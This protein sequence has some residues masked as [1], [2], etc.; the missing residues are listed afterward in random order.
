MSETYVYIDGFN[1]YYGCIKGTA[2]KWLDLDAFCQRL[3]PKDDIQQIRYFTAKVAARPHD[4]QAP[5]RQETYLRALATIPKLSIHFGHFL[6]NI[7]TLPLARP[8]RIGSRKAQVVKT[9]EKGSDVN[10]AAHA[11]L[12]GF[13]HRYD[14]AVI[15]SND[16][17]L[18]EPVR[19]IRYELGLHV[20]V[21][22]PHPAR[23][24]SR[25][26]STEAH[27]FKQVRPSTLA[28]SQ[29]PLTLNDPVG[30]FSKP[31]GW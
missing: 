10:L 17:D 23:R 12:D 16:S 7:V 11:L 21:I 9:E 20:G 14:T 28:S 26:L 3:L 25:Q 13:R 19:I 18:T 6:T 27:F 1:L 29:F 22:N 15:I 24:R 8:P 2:Y 5:Q 31:K 30:R 4:P